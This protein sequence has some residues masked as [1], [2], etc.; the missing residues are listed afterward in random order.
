MHFISDAFSRAWHAGPLILCNMRQSNHVP[1]QGKHKVERNFSF[2]RTIN[3]LIFPAIVRRDYEPFF[4]T[5]AWLEKRQSLRKY[6]R[7]GNKLNNRCILG[8]AIDC[9]KY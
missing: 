5:R 6:D 8:Q 7:K 1:A 3:G 4:I 9:R 2:L